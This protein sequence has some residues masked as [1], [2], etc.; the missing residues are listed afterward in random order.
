MDY[1][2]ILKEPI[3]LTKIPTW[4]IRFQMMSIYGDGK[5]LNTPEYNKFYKEMQAELKRRLTINQ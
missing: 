4:V 5:Y 1:E 3:D 2:K